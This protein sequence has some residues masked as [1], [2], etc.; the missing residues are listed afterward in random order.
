MSVKLRHLVSFLSTVLFLVQSVHAALPAL[1]MGQADGNNE[2]LAA[3][4][5]TAVFTLN[6]TAGNFVVVN[7]RI[8]AQGRMITVV[9]ISDSSC[10][11]GNQF[12]A[13][14]TLNFS[15]AELDQY[16][17][18]NIT[19][20]GK[21]ITT[22]VS[23]SATNIRLTA[24]EYS[25][26]LTAGSPLDQAA[27]SATGVG[28]ACASGNI[29][30]ITSNT[31]AVGACGDATAGTFTVGAGWSNL[32]VSPSGASAAMAQEDQAIAAA[33]TTVNA[34]FTDASG[35]WGAFV[36]VYKS[37]SGGGGGLLL[38]GKGKKLQHDDADE[39]GEMMLQ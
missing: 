8:S 23:S 1:V 11:T 35:S 27:V 17:L 29:T 19:A 36:V 3:T 21:T 15:T 39:L 4:S 34:Q 32:T 20:F 25:G 18:Q 38:R 6:V 9:D 13:A 16:Y 26:V 24:G 5:C 31:L 7:N 28:T 30:T 14:K 37:A 10:A 2:C 12:T 22:C 33:S